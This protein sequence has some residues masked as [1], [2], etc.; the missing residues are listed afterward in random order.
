MNLLLR[1]VG[2]KLKQTDFQINVVA[3]SFGKAYNFCRTLDTLFHRMRY[4][5][6]NHSIDSQKTAKFRKMAN[7]SRNNNFLILSKN[8]LRHDQ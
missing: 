4:F 6:F 1:L 3:E 5:L 8:H 7:I 2:S